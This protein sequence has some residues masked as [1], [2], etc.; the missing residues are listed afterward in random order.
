[1]DYRS[2]IS[3]CEA[4]RRRRAWLGDILPGAAINLHSSRAATQRRGDADLIGGASIGMIS[5]DVSWLGSDNWSISWNEFRGDDFA[6]LDDET[7]QAL[8]VVLF[9]D[10]VE[11][12]TLL[13]ASFF[14]DFPS[15]TE[16]TETCRFDT[17]ATPTGYTEVG[18]SDNST[19]VFTD[20]DNT[21]VITMKV[22]NKTTAEVVRDYQ[23]LVHCLSHASGEWFKPSTVS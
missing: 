9:E 15:A 1:V 11:K 23:D 8:K 2:L 13:N 20:V 4:C 19:G 12:V 22:I 10:G 3:G 16:N 14:F 21:A 6:D 5:V 17:V 18:W 7:P